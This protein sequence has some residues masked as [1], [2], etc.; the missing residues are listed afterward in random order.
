MD[1]L[2]LSGNIWIHSSDLSISESETHVN[3]VSVR[4]H[5][6]MSACFKREQEAG[7]LLYIYEAMLT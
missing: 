3:G 7:L 5:E 4:G 6:D 1:I 2:H